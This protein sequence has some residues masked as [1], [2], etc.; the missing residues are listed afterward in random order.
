MEEGLNMLDDYLGDFYIRK[1]L[2]STP[3]NIKSTARQ[4]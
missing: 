2:W 3:G 1:C 4:V